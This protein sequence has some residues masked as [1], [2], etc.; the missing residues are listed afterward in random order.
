VGTTRGFWKIDSLLSVEV[1]FVNDPEGCESD[2]ICIGF[3][4]TL[5]NA[6]L[7]DLTMR[8]G[9]S[10]VRTLATRFLNSS[11]RKSS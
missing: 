5:D 1:V 3:L 7:L 4:R 2:F 11:W 8:Y 9:D 10:D 6:M